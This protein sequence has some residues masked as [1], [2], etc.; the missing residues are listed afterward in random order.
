MIRVWIVEDNASFRNAVLQEINDSEGMRCEEA[1][2]SCEALLEQLPK[3][4]PPDAIILD[5]RLPGLSGLEAI[6]SVKALSP[7]SQILMLT[8]FDD[9]ER[10]FRALCAGASGYLL[11]TS[12][13]DIPAAIREVVEGGAA[14]SP[15]IARSVLNLFARLSPA[16]ADYRLTPRER[17]I[18]ELMVQGLIKKEI[19]ERLQLSYHTVDGHLRK[20]YRKLHVNN[21]SGAVAKA[22]S[23]R[24]C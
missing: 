3:V 14:L 7:G 9:Q 15:P 22:V 1:F 20:I 6:A 18:L 23:E 16:P 13:E 11:K 4:S 2:P 12:N 24:L 10:I 5:I 8:M 19:A 17:S 21:A